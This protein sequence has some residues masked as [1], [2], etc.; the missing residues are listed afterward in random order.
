MGLWADLGHR[1]DSGLRKT[2]H[3]LSCRRR[4]ALL[5][6]PGELSL[7]TAWQCATGAMLSRAGPAPEFFATSE[8]RTGRANLTALLEHTCQ[9]PFFEALEKNPTPSR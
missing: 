8:S 3:I 5:F 6:P 7:P 1:D 2:W 4:A 9:H